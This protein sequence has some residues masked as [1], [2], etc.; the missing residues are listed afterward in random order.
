[1]V[2]APV[3]AS[4]GE[5]LA[6]TGNREGATGRMPF[7]RIN[8]LEQVRKSYPDITG[9]ADE[10]AMAGWLS[11]PLVAILTPGQAMRH[12]DYINRVYGVSHRMSDLIVLSYRPRRRYAILIAGHCRLLANQLLWN[13]G[14]SACR[15][16]YGREAQGI[17]Y[18]RHASQHGQ[19]GDGVIDVKLYLGI[20]P[21][22]AL[23]K[24]FSE[25]RYNRPPPQEVADGLD[26][27][28]AVEYCEN[29]DLT[30]TAFAKIASVSADTFRRAQRYCRLPEDIRTDVEVGRLRFGVALELGRLAEKASPEVVEVCHQAFLLQATTVAQ[31]TKIIDGEIS[32]LL[33]W[34]SFEGMGG[35]V[36]AGEAKRAMRKPFE[37]G[38]VHVIYATA[39][40]FKRAKEAIARGEM[41]LPDGVYRDT[42]LMHA[43]REAIAIQSALLPDIRRRQG[44][45]QTDDDQ[46]ILEEVAFLLDQKSPRPAELQTSV[47]IAVD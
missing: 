32:H 22:L 9:L 47:L 1:M 15:K 36:I 3:L 18:Q 43:W 40:L 16:Q 34:S 26:R 31:A 24:Q 14:C 17:C 6:T 46:A 29:P 21:R 19:S 44:A 37:R 4:Q 20:E 42:T 13:E 38:L 28:F 23:S 2:A 8:M 10:F 45:E 11:D 25:N 35:A 30:P 5:S 39:P 33:N 27:W 41:G 12:L 7:G